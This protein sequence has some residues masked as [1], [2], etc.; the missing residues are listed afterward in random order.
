[1]RAL[2]VIQMVCCVAVASALTACGGGTPPPAPTTP[3]AGGD[4]I[5]GSERIGWDQVASD[6]SEVGRYRYAFYLDDARREAT[7]VSCT[8]ATSGVFACSGRLPL[9]SSGAHTLQVAAFVQDGDTIVE[10]ARS[11]GLRVTI[12]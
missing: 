2:E 3:P 7:D 11:D 5:T 10:S 12:R 8:A 4:A 9:M 6:A 1:M